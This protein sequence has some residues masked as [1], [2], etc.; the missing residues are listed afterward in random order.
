MTDERVLAGERRYGTLLMECPRRRRSMVA[1][2]VDAV[3]RWP[4]VTAAGFVGAVLGVDAL[5]RW[6]IG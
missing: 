4:V 5:G 3:L 2:V 6:L 1:V